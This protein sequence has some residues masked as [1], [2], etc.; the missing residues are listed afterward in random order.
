METKQ[1]TLGAN[2]DP[3]G[4]RFYDGESPKFERKQVRSKKKRYKKEMRFVKA[5]HFVAM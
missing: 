3:K 5:N 2:G 1:S 4:G